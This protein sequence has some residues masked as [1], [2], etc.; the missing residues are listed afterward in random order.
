MRNLKVLICPLGNSVE[1]LNLTFAALASR[2]DAINF[3]IAGVIGDGK[4]SFKGRELKNISPSS[5]PETDFDYIIAVGGG[6]LI[7][8]LPRRRKK[9]LPNK[10]THRASQSYSTLKFAAG[11]SLSRKFVWSSSSITGSIKTCRCSVRFTA[12]DFPTFGF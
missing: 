9:L 12:S 2:Y 4:V 1:S 6:Y 5:V 10:S 8:R 3:D 11:R 7:L